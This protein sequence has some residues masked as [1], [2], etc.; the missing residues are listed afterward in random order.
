MAKVFGFPPKKLP[1]EL[2]ALRTFRMVGWTMLCLC[3]IAPVSQNTAAITPEGAERTSLTQ[4][5]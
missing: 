3:P 4:S 2:A 1:A 5:K